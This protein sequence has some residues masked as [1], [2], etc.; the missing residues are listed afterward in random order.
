MSSTGLAET[1]RGGRPAPYRALVQRW[2]PLLTV[3]ATIDITLAYAVVDHGAGEIILAG[4]IGIA[5]LALCILRPRPALL[6]FVAFWGVAHVL[7]SSGSLEA[8]GGA[9]TSISQLFGATVVLGLVTA[10]APNSRSASRQVPLPLRLFGVF[11]FLYTVAE[12]IT[13]LHVAG[14]SDLAKLLGGLALAFVG[15]YM[16]DNEKRLLSLARAVSVSGLLVALVALVQAI[17]GSS[18]GLESYA[19]DTGPYRA[20]SALGSASATA[21]FLLICAGF[22]LLRYT[23]QRDKDR[24]RGRAD[25]AILA[26]V[27][28]GIVVTLTRADII[29]LVVMLVV[30]TGLWQ[31][32]S[33]SAIGI[34]TRLA[35]TLVAIAVVGVYAVGSATLSSR[36]QDLN[37]SSGATFL[38][39]RGAIWS[40]ELQTLHSADVSAIL[41]GSGAHTSY[42]SVYLAQSDK[43]RE[44]PPHDLFLWLAIETGAVGLIV[45]VSALFTL[46]RSLLIAARRSRFT[47]A[48]QVA[49]VALA[50]TIAFTLDSMF[51]N[52]QVST[53][54]DWYFML[55]VGATLR[56]IEPRSWKN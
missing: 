56:M 29:A 15:Y 9:S 54:S 36:L 51:H 53:G 43:S 30:W 41:I 22:A 40:N 17:A 45:Y 5:L 46:G 33:V 4:G 13:P 52:T 24:R 32:R 44:F 27:S 20:T 21:D 28:L 3:I 23:L 34:R 8:T 38:N 49:A 2:L 42:T 31:M 6:A 39:G 16:I 19:Q 50:T 11:A 48:G 18:F 25:L 26:V 37:P 10:A 7:L 35:L 14:L 1:R 55:F 12:L 47:P